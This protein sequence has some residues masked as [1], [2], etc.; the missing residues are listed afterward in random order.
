M[1]RNIIG[2]LQGL[3]SL[4]IVV[5]LIVG[6]IYMAKSKKG[7]TARILIGAG[8]VLIP[9]VIMMVLNYARVASLKKEIEK[10]NSPNTSIEMTSDIIINGKTISLPCD[11]D[12]FMEDTGLKTYDTRYR[13]PANEVWVTDGNSYFQLRKNYDD[14]VTGIA[15]THNNFDTNKTSIIFTNGISLYSSFS[16]VQN[17]LGKGDGGQLTNA[18][19]IANGNL[20]RVY[21][22]KS[23]DITFEVATSN[24]DSAK[25]LMI[26]I[27][28]SANTP[29]KSSSTDNQTEIDF[30]N[31]KNSIDNGSIKIAD[32]GQ[33][34][35]IGTDLYMA[36]EGAGAINAMEVPKDKMTGIVQSEDREFIVLDIK[37][38]NGSNTSG[39]TFV[40]KNLAYVTNNTPSNYY[41]GLFCISDMSK[42]LY[43]Y[44]NRQS[45]IDL[46]SSAMNGSVHLSQGEEKSGCIILYMYSEGNE[47]YLYYDT[48]SYP[49]SYVHKL[50]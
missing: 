3:N 19:N 15:I 13:G 26:E 14:Y 16:D 44:F 8:I 43:D 23:S 9:F 21:T 5:C 31:I 47:S 10:F 2:L 32:K 38:R 1:S 46:S 33:E 28:S 34:I 41:G 17:K 30:T 39:N 42:S 24:D 49:T 25:I 22:F 50:K 45:L 7:K 36:I 11:Y 35:Q 37:I 12:K 27:I 6:V 29:E 40:G 20:Y 48:E 18:L 4:L